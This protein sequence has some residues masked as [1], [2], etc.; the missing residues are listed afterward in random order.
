MHA[1]D[2]RSGERREPL[3]LNSTSAKVSIEQIE[4]GGSNKSNN[5]V[6]ASPAGSL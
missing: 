1:E 2:A 5:G 3:D 6:Q 4:L